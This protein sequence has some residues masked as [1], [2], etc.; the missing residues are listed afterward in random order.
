[1]V[2]FHVPQITCHIIFSSCNIMKSVS[3]IDLNKNENKA[4]L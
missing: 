2:D 4:K 1:M 3:Q